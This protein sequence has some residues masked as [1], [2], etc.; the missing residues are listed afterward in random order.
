MDAAYRGRLAPSPTGLLHRGHA[1]TF[2]I[3]QQR[4]E[5]A[6]GALILRNDDLDRSRCRPEFVEAM[7]ED[8]RWLGLRWTE[9]PDLGAPHAPY[10]Q[11]ER[12]SLYR[13]AFDRLRAGGFLFPCP[14]S[15]QDVLR[16]L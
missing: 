5:A 14:C 11:S 8:M 2:W 9:G 15:R 6:L 3:L 12:L 10:T 1:R 7:F 16:A 13:A 4:A